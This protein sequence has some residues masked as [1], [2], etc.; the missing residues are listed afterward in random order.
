MPGTPRAGAGGRPD[1]ISE[2]CGVFAVFN[3]P[4]AAHLTYLGLL[5]LQHRGQDS[6]GIVAADGAAYERQRKLGLVTET[7]DR[8]A[9]QRLGAGDK[10][11]ALGH[12]CSAGSA[13]LRPD[14]VQPL[15]L[16]CRGEWLAIAYNGH[17]VDGPRRRAELAEA[18]AR[19][20]TACDVEVIAHLAARAEGDWPEAL[21]A[22]LRSLAGGYALA[23]LTPRGVFAARD[24]HGIRPL[25]L[26]RLDQ[27]TIVASET[28]ALTSIG[29]DVVRAIAPGERVWIDRDGVRTI[30][31]EAAPQARFCMFELVYFARPDSVF[32]GR[33]VYETRKAL[34]R[35]LAEEAPVDADL[36]IGVPDSSLPAAVG[37]SEAAGIPHELGL[38]KNRYVGRTFIRPDPQLRKET[39]QIK[40]HP[41]R[42]LVNGK[43]VVIV[44]DSLVRGTTARRLV[45]V[46]HDA[47]AAEVHLRI[48]SPPFRHPC[49]YGIYAGDG[50][51]P[52]SQYAVDDL[53]KLV[54]ADS[55]HFLSEEG[56]IRATGLDHGAFC[57]ACFNGDYPV[58]PQQ[59]GE[60]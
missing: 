35:V 34:G 20:L 1:A 52:A 10:P 16:P 36:V 51:F 39:T 21:T 17:F 55:L 13:G 5:A 27:A 43:R 49:H 41:I 18:G 23:A 7:F 15:L 9:L 25:V 4:D 48:S 37:Y 31:V 53:R 54:G 28:S 50:Q 29:A 32:H 38:I 8:E 11:N 2:R 12:V 40:L 44:D 60:R 42:E 6:A 33:S 26:G 3:H 22:A 46:M 19:L 47:G 45:A 57:L 58:P 56:L 59:G 24:P 30:A 14:D